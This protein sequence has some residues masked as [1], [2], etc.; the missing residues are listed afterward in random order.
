VIRLYADFNAR[1]PEGECHIMLHE[2]MHLDQ[3]AERL[4]LKAG[5]RVLLY[6][7]DDDFE[8]EAI[9]DYRYVP[10]L[11]GDAWLAIP[12]WTTMRDMCLPK[13]D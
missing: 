12:D 9:L 2:G 1:T 8:V 6:Q 7:D 3:A 5:N 11:L 4:Q 13:S 10:Y